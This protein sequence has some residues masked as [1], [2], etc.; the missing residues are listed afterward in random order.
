MV[1]KVVKSNPNMFHFILT[2]IQIPMKAFF[3]LEEKYQ[4]PT[5]M[6]FID[7]STCNIM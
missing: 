1:N 3:C 2:A 7:M 4:R 5:K 6:D